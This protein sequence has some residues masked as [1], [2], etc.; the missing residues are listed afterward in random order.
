[1]N[2]ELLEAIG[3]TKSEINVYLALLEL[4]SSSTGKIVDKSKASSSKI[5]EILNRLMQKGLVSFIIKSGVKYFEA[6]PPDRIMDY[7]KEKEA[8]IKQ[9][10]EEA[11][12][13]IPELELKRKLSKYKSEATIFKGL[14]GAK[15]AYDDVLR[16]MKKGE[17]YYVLGSGEPSPELLRFYRHYHNRRSKKGIKVKLLFSEAGR[18]WADNMKGIPLTEIKFAPSQLFTSSF[19]LMY[20]DKTLITVSTKKEVTL[21][22]I[23]SKEVT[24]SFKSQFDLLWDQRLQTYEGSSAVD[25]AYDEMLRSAKPGD[26]MVMFAT[27][28]ES[29]GRADFNLQ[30]VK[31]LS[32]KISDARAIYY[33]DNEANRERTKDFAKIGCKTK[34]LPTMQSLPIS[35]VVSGDTIL[36]SVWGKKPLTFRIE[37]KT[38]ADSLRH[39][40]ELL[41][42][43]D[44]VTYKGEEGVK[45]VF[46]QVLNEKE[47]WFIGGNF[48]IKQFPEYWEWFK[49]ERIKR[50]NFWHDLIDQGA[51]EIDDLSGEPYYEYKILP[52]E[53]KS[54]HVIGIF[55]NKVANIIWAGKHTRIFVVEDKDL[56]DG[57]KKY[58]HLL[59]DQDTT[60][61]KGIEEL[62]RV[63]E[64][65]LNGLETG[66]TYNVL[67]ATFGVDDSFFNRKEY[68]EVFKKIHQLR[69][70]KGI[71]ARLL[72]QQRPGEVISKFRKAIYNKDQEAKILPYKTD[73]PVAILPSKKK[74]VIIV[75]KE[76]PTTISINNE[77]A[78]QAFQKHFA[79]LWDQEVNI[80][81]GPDGIKIAFQ[82][83]VDELKPGEEV[84]I[85][86][87]Y[88]FGEEFLP[89]ALFFQEIRSKKGIKAKFLMNKGA[90][91]IAERFKDY[92]PVEIKFMPEKIFTPAIFLIYKD[93]VI[94]NLAK[95]QTFFVMQSKSA[96][97]AFES[98][99]QLMW[100]Q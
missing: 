31:E 2:V 91:K 38:V 81:K 73:F 37:N 84:H 53:M 36:N 49:K 68:A 51:L 22:R 98:Y 61:H 14:K 50:K 92:P 12:K 60:V 72:F 54:P 97:L 39:N 34:I 48:G 43:Q 71:K 27:K 89:L 26:N 32:S 46:N 40:F 41:W 58:F 17:E 79:S 85:M 3:L 82:N 86:G 47:V 24:D 83:L 96:A 69:A 8:R 11:Q 90:K 95:E 25:N 59:W 63:L 75:Q 64:D 44:T 93:K 42:E 9:Q 65:Y 29:K 7:I 55:G 66:E 1:M 21:F 56:V 76:E 74:T 87:V 78:S 88:D 23:D 35:T 30:W 15:T 4:G 33:G 94:I 20:A 19:V 77:E 62:Y 99:F 80:Y 100:N 57:Y 67:G 28:P 16:T 6:A 45:A 70:D 52:P 18:R 13:L 5:Y 10:K